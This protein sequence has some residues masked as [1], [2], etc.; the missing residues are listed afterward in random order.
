MAV[1]MGDWGVTDYTPLMAL[2]P[3]SQNL[4]EELGIFSEA[5]TEYLD[6]EFA[7][8]EREEKG[9]TGMYN[10]S[11]GADRQFAG[12][13]S[14]RK[15]LFRVPFATLDAITKPQEVNAFREYGTENTPASVERLVER[16]IE[17]I[18]RSHARY[19]RDVQYHALVSNKVFAFDKDG[20]E[21]TGLAKNYS[22]VWGAAR[23]TETLDLSDAST[24]PFIALGKG[25]TNVIQ[26]AGDDG[27][28]YDI[29]YLLNST[30]FDAIISHPIVQAAYENYPSEQEPL[31]RRLSGNRN[32]R[33]F[34]H[35][36]VVLVED[37]S[38]KIVNTKGFMLPIGF[39]GLTAAAYAPADTIEHVNTMSEGSY[40]FMKENYRSTTIES[41]V[42]YMVSLNRPE[43]ITEFTVT[44]PA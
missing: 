21:L 5:T 43:L 29:L 1:R 27:D 35:K 16:K 39:E 3:R 22:T 18:Q 23:N 4:L 11:R 2:K 24:D 7:E 9:L 15:E 30:Q 8:F 12:T 34:R 28:N 40:L 6:G 26:N 31:R 10:V 17:H 41:E 37:I 25:R 33:T 19:V 44:L 20:N 42:S 14:A 13:E 38:G 36:G 32:N